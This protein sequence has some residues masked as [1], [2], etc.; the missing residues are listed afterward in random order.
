MQPFVEVVAD[1]LLRA[2]L[3]RASSHFEAQYGTSKRP[4]GGIGGLSLFYPRVGADFGRFEDLLMCPGHR[5]V[6]LRP[7]EFITRYVVVYRA[8]LGYF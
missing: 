3:F 6:Y 2:Y 7:C 4:Q 1:A 5:Y 8:V